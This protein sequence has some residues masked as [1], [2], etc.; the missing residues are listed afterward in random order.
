MGRGRPK[1]NESLIYEKLTPEEKILENLKK[2]NKKKGIV[3]VE[4]APGRG[5]PKSELNQIL[6]AKPVR[7][8][9]KF[10]NENGTFDYWVWNSDVLRGGPFITYAYLNQEE[11]DELI[12]VGDE[13]YN[14]NYN[15]KFHQVRAEKQRKIKDPKKEKTIKTTTGTGKRGRPA[16][17]NKIV[18]AKGNGKRGRPKKLVI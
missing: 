13:I 3:T 15:A 12:G 11:V 8:V 6:D 1:S 17:P 18:K 5:R 16:N 9:K 4:T 7:E 14:P 10:D 2:Y